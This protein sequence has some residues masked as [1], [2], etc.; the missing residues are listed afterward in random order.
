VRHLQDVGVRR[1]RQ[2]ELDHAGGLVPVAVEQ[3][4]VRFDVGVV[5]VVARH[6]VFALAEDLAVRDAG[7]VGDLLE[8]PDSLER[9]EDALHAV[10]DLHRHRVQGEAAGLLEI[11]EL[12]DLQAVEPDLPAQA[13]GAES[14]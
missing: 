14:R 2:A 9:H 5:E 11:G 3:L 13:P 8:V 6:L 10:G 12:G 7:S 1:D 4:P